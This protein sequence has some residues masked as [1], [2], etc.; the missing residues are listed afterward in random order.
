MEQVKR[1]VIKGISWRLVGTADTFLISWLLTGE[2]KVAGS[3]ALVEVVSK[4]ALFTVHERL[5]LRVKWGR[6]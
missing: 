2:A 3:I 5:W 1:S 6:T 4:L